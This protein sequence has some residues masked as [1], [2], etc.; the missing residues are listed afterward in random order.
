LFFLVTAYALAVGY[1]PH[2]GTAFATASGTTSIVGVPNLST[3]NV[4]SDHSR[5]HQISSRPGRH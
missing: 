2:G 4:A 5:E 3:S 1:G